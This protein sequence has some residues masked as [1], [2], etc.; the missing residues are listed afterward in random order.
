MILVF[1]FS[2]A[3]EKQSQP[4]LFWLLCTETYTLRFFTLNTWYL[5]MFSRLS[6]FMLLF[7]SHCS[8]SRFVS[9]CCLEL[10]WLCCSFFFSSID[11]ESSWCIEEFNDMSDSSLSLSFQ[12]MQSLSLRCTFLS[13]IR[14]SKHGQIW[15]WWPHSWQNQHTFQ[16]LFCYEVQPHVSWLFCWEFDCWALHE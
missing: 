3:C 2:T 9:W 1:Q 7:K 12:T 16:S 14:W 10:V 8:S 6:S 15:W 13:S 11:T 4:H 5:K